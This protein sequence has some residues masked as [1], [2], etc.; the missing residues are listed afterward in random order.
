MPLP[1]KH[2]RMKEETRWKL[3]AAFGLVT[4]SIILYSVHYAL[5]HDEH[6]IFIFFVGDL[7]F[8]PVEIL[9]VT[10]IIDQMLESREKKNRMEKLNM[11]IGTFFSTLGTPLLSMLSRTDPG[12]G[13]VRKNLVVGAGWD[14]SRFREVQACLSSHACGVAIDRMDP[15]ALKAFLLAREEFIIRLV[16]NPMVFEHETFTDLLLAISH[17]M[18]ELKARSDLVQLPPLDI[19]HL[20]GD[21]ARVYERLVP[22]WLKYME[23]L[24]NHYPYLFSLAMRTNP[25]DESASVIVKG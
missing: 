6:H 15:E 24:K 5:F 18:E 23:Y 10:L 12:I 3:I 7:A 21:L 4:L 1:A 22:E 14:A 11:V 8:V 16:E 13:T 19:A 17:L 2:R 9:I 20:N 25:F